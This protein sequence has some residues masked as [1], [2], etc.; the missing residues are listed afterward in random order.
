MHNRPFV[1]KG[2][3]YKSES[4]SNCRVAYV[5][6]N[7]LFQALFSFLSWPTFFRSLGKE[8]KSTAH[9]DSDHKIVEPRAH[10]LEKSL[11]K[12]IILK[13]NYFK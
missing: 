6:W 9:F 11:G 3:T 1:K 8:T 7:T 2:L 12:G 13:N 4:S 5:P 10:L